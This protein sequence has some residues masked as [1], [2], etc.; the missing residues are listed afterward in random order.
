MTEVVKHTLGP[1]IVEYDTFDEALHVTSQDRLDGDKVEIARVS[2]G[3][4]DAFEVEQ[5]ANA[6]LIA[7]APK[8]L[9]ALKSAAERLKTMASMTGCCSDDEWVW[10][11]QK[12]V[13]EAIDLATQEKP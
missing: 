10:A 8:M 1:W 7:A 9:V 4:A 6:L 13:N 12:Q 11:A 3:Y 2:I 5:Q